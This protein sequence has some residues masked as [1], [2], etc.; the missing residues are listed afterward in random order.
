MKIPDLLRRR[1]AVQGLARPVFDTPADAVSWMGA[2]QAQDY[3][4]ALW[5]LDARVQ[6]AG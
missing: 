3:L 5:G 6:M 1:L 2:I 4:G